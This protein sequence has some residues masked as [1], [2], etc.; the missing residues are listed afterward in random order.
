VAFTGGGVLALCL[1]LGGAGIIVV[2]LVGAVSASKADH[3]ER[4]GEG[5]GDRFSTSAAMSILSPAGDGRKLSGGGVAPLR[6]G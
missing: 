1:G 6:V 4:V 3:S 2:L 5:G